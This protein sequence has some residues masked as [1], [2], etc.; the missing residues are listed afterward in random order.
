MAITDSGFDQ[1]AHFVFE[2]LIFLEDFFE[3][4][5]TAL[6]PAVSVFLLHRLDVAVCLERRIEHI[7]FILVLA[8]V[9]HR[10]VLRQT[11]LVQLSL[12]A[13]NLLRPLRAHLGQLPNLALPRPANLF[14]PLVHTKG[15]LLGQLDLAIQVLLR[16]DLLLGQG[17]N[18]E[19]ELAHEGGH[20]EQLAFHVTDFSEDSSLIIF[21]SLG[22]G[23]LP[24][25]ESAKSFLFLVSHVTIVVQVIVF[26]L[27][28]RIRELRGLVVEP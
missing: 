14:L 28:V 17:L 12:Q 10:L 3:A 11:S 6:L 9:V 7:D 26:H 27:L 5:K 22:L 16:A 15:L 24:G 21:Q 19:L 25:F 8:Q 20:I 2:P 4:I 13:Q 23:S 18:F 1:C